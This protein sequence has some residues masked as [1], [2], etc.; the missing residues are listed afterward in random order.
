MASADQTIRNVVTGETS[1]FLVTAADSGGALLEL[2]MQADPNA[3]GG[4]EHIHPRIKETH[5]MLEGVLHFKLEGVETT[6]EAGQRLEIP[7]GTA[8]SFWN[9]DDRPA[10]TRVRFEPAGEFEHFMESYYAL[11]ADGKLDAKGRPKLLQS[12]LIGR[13]HIADIALARP[14]VFLQRLLYAA[15]APVAR[16]RGYRDRYPA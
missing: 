11:A 5:Q 8:H 10:R 7:P 15:L 1:T 3:A 2:E 14:P 13:R 4:S 9:A 16:V 12:A 6:I